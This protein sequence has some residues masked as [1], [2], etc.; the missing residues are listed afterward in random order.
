MAQSPSTELAAVQAPDERD[1]AYDE[2][3]ARHVSA[4]RVL[5]LF[6]PYAGRITL[7]FLLIA[8]ASAAGLAA[9]LLLREIID[10]ALPRGDMPLQAALAASLIGL[11][12]IGAAIGV[13][14]ALFTAKVGQAVMH[15]LRVAVYAHLQALP[16]GFF[17]ATRAGDIQSRIA[18]DIGA[19]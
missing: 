2:M 6:R 17:A 13:L 18:S 15:D 4:V 12:A 5:G 19:L 7:V 11:T 9:P 14:Q 1:A 8:L 16:L 3:A 10:V